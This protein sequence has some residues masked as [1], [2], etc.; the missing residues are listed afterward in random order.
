MAEEPKSMVRIASFLAAGLLP[1]LGALI[2]SP[3]RGIAVAAAGAS[4]MAIGF[5][6]WTQRLA[7]ELGQ[8]RQRDSALRNDVSA[9]EEKVQAQTRELRDVRTNDEVTG[10]LN[11]G[12]FLRRLDETIA[13]DGRLGKPVTFLLVD[14]QGFRAINNEQGRLGGDAALKA[15]AAAIQG[16][17]RGTDVVG[18]FGGDEFGIVLGECE[19][20][21]PAV[22]RLFLA[23]Q[24]QNAVTGATQIH[25]G[26]GAVTVE[27][28]AGGVETAELF[29]LA[30]GALASVRGHAGSL[31]ARRTLKNDVSSAATA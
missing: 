30:E 4:I 18:R 8:L 13:R 5:V 28:P 16:A 22:N 26:V 9:L 15:L 3:T 6:V 25:V 11:R 23:L 2:V 29:R 14:V 27:N 1:C 19:D 21:R 31:C 7:S 24:A 12:S 17:T 20:P 10:T